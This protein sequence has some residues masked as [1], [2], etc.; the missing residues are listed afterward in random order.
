M[1]FEPC[2]SY[3]ALKNILQP[4]SKI[5]F[6]E[7][8]HSYVLKNDLLNGLELSNMEPTGCLPS[9]VSTTKM[10][11]HYFPSPYEATAYRILKSAE[12]VLKVN[13]PPEEYQY[14]NCYTKEDIMSRWGNGAKLGTEMHNHFELMAN[15]LEMDRDC[16]N[17]V[18]NRYDTYIQSLPSS[19]QPEL[20]LFTLFCNQ[21]EIFKGRRRFFRTE[22]RCFN[23]ALLITGSIDGIL[24]DTVTDCYIIID[25]KRLK[26]DLSGGPT[27]K[28]RKSIEDTSASGKGIILPSLMQTR[29]NQFS[30]YGCQLT[31][32]KHL[33]QWLH[34]RK[35]VGLF[36]INMIMENENPHF[37]PVEIPLHEFDQHTMEMFQ[38]RANDIFQ[39]IEFDDR[40]S[41]TF[42]SELQRYV[43]VSE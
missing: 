1:D 13:L 36:L 15:L 34:G 33:F 17:G 38:A 35:V 39:S 41:D 40:I 14:A 28:P 10:I 23:E 18:H 29:N 42:K 43:Q 7:E 12:H 25:Y 21:F 37:Q 16:V 31:V 32:Y 6:R 2:R 24:F 9:L 22:I 4:D 5:V 26:S 27:Y 8:G 30:Q 11:H 3:L 19:F 20:K